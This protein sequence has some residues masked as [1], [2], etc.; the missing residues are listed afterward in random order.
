MAKARVLK[1]VVLIMWSDEIKTHFLGGIQR[2]GLE[3]HSWFIQ[4]VETIG[5]KFQVFLIFNFFNY[6]L[7]ANVRVL[8]PVVLVCI[9][10]KLVN[11]L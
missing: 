6:I 3:S 4:W 11:I 2:I 9:L 5:L 10:H 1:P 8:K 7:M